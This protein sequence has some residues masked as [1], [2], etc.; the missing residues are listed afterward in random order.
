[1]RLATLRCCAEF[2][3]SQQ[4]CR[5]FFYKD[6]L[7]RLRKKVICVRPDI[8]DK[9]MLH[10]DNALWHT[11]HHRIFDSSSTIHLT[12]ALVTFSFFLNMKMSSKHG[13]LENIQKSAMEMLKTINGWRLPVL[14]P[15]IGTTSPSV[16]SWPREVLWRG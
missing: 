6:V 16:C 11:A 12:S 3:P 5:L 8:A 10:N 2:V 1:M 7:E 14:L 4:N 13:N 15:K 9:W